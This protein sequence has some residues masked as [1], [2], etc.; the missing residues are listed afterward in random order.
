MAVS[1]AAGPDAAPHADA[2]PNRGVPVDGE[3][4]YLELGVPDPDAARAFYGRLFGW[5]FSGEQGAGQ[6][7]TSPL[8]I[9]LHG[10]D[11]GAHFEV[12]FAVPDLDAGLREVG[13][14]GGSVHGGVHDSGP[15]G[16]WAECSD[17]QNVRFG[18]RELPKD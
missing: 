14:L 9:G 13:L 16:R 3:P 15:F 8:G 7:E 4:S 17:D 11:D 2:P 12:F 5:R 18:L 1:Q 6:A 10:D